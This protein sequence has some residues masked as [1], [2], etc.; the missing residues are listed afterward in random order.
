[1]QVKAKPGNSFYR[2]AK[3]HLNMQ[4]KDKIIALRLQT[5]IVVMYQV[6]SFVSLSCLSTT[7]C[8]SSLLMQRPIVNL[9]PEHMLCYLWKSE[10]KVKIEYPIE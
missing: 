3:G 9:A 4:S 7:F 2:F 8:I 6:H 5:A 1:V 10:E